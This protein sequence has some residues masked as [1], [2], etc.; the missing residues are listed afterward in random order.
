MIETLFFAFLW[1]QGMLVLLPPIPDP[2]AIL[3]F[4]A[5]VCAMLAHAR[6][7]LLGTGAPQC[8]PHMAAPH[9]AQQRAASVRGRSCPSL[10]QRGCSNQ[11][12]LLCNSRVVAEPSRC[13]RPL[14]SPT[15]TLPDTAPSPP[16]SDGQQQHTRTTRVT[17]PARTTPLPHARYTRP[18]I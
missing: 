15:H 14:P 3:S 10:V 11:V 1:H 4:V 18:S 17:R 9:P 7:C 13:P 2:Q 12:L 16:P 5:C 6:P 8:G